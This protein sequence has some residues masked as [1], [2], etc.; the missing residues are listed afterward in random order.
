MPQDG[1]GYFIHPEIFLATLFLIA[2]TGAMA[3]G[4]GS[5]SPAFYAARARG[6]DLRAQGE[7]N[8]DLRTHGTSWA[9]AWARSSFSPIS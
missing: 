3:Y 1:A 5:V 7:G 4:L 8:L 2:L 6:T 9:S